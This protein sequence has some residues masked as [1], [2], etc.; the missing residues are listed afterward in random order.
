[1]L[2]SLT[3][4]ICV[5]RY[6]DSYDIEKGLTFL[7]E[8]QIVNTYSTVDHSS[9]VLHFAFDVIPST[10]VDKLIK[11]IN[12]LKLEV[13]TADYL[14]SEGHITILRNL[15]EDTKSLVDTLKFYFFYMA[16]FKGNDLGKFVGCHQQLS[17][18]TSSKFEDL[19]QEVKQV[20]DILPKNITIAQLKSDSPE[21]NLMSDRYLYLKTQVQT[22]VQ[23]T[24]DFVEYLE[25]INR[26]V[27]SS[28]L[29]EIL[30][31]SPCDSPSAVESLEVRGCSRTES[32]FICQIMVTEMS[33]KGQFM[34]MYAIPYFD[35]RVKIPTIFK[36]L[37]NDNLLLNS[38]C[39]THD[40][41]NYFFCENTPLKDAC[42]LALIT[43]SMTDTIKSCHFEDFDTIEN[44]QEP[45]YKGV[46]FMAPIPINF[47]HNN[48]NTIMESYTPTN[49]SVPFVVQY[50]NKLSFKVGATTRMYT[51]VQNT[52]HFTP[53]KPGKN[54]II[55]TKFTD[56]E[57]KLLKDSFLPPPH[58]ILDINTYLNPMVFIPLIIG[59]IVLG[60]VLLCAY[61][62]RARI[63]HR[64]Q[65]LR[66]KST[67]PKT[68]KE[69]RKFLKSPPK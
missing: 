22:F 14:S 23:T 43:G 30:R 25:T 47:L 26:H 45:M 57:I 67:S 12:T 5:T 56:A 52:S 48:N 42:T 40:G 15:I 19:L 58:P 63:K 33:D 21:F 50:V 3:I 69:L 16:D 37:K 2:L 61:N 27:I 60:C 6:V 34:K 68:S 11:V 9:I 35:K 44:H 54:K 17:G 13:L 66:G 62:C 39:K 36:D 46:L 20:V 49:S 8:E 10:E 18:I 38:S 31:L 28:N 64:A 4:L 29:H 53:D 1:M 59:A 24:Q 65:R 32:E 41:V 7:R 51:P 55:I